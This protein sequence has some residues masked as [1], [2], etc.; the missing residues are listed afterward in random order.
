MRASCIGIVFALAAA[1]PGFS[2]A[3]A[4]EAPV[5][6]TGALLSQSDSA[7]T[8]RAKDG[9]DISVPMSPGWT[10]VTAR[11]VS[12]DTIKPGDFIAS[13]N[14]DLGPTS[15][16][17]TEVRVLEAGYRPENSTHPMGPSMSMTHGTVTASKADAAGQELDVS[18]PGG[19][20]HLLAPT[21]T[22]VTAYDVH[23]RS[24]LKL[25]ATVTAVT[26]KDADG[27]GRASRLL[28]GPDK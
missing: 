28:V 10:V 19:A 26:R 14:S 25:G 22:P 18:F 4:P 3:Q 12:A 20:R 1:S 8:L 9:A 27:V 17:S 16:K 2:A 15:G 21:G 5:S 7:V 23:D 24:F 11:P 6:H 13:A